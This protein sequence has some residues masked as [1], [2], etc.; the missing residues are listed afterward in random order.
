MLSIA[1]GSSNRL[2]LLPIPI[3]PNKATETSKWLGWV[4]ESLLPG[5]V[6]SVP[7]AIRRDMMLM[8]LG[9]MADVPKELADQIKRLEDLFI[10]SQDKLKEI[11]ERFKN[12]LIKGTFL[13]NIRTSSVLRCARP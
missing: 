7:S 10:I 11:T 1:V 5:R 4:L 3:D 2:T 13:T 12:E 9:S 6:S 8:K